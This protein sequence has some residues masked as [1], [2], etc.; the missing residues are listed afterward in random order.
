MHEPAARKVGISES[1]F[2]KRGTSAVL[3][4]PRNTEVERCRKSKAGKKKEIRGL[5]AA[6]AQATSQ[7]PGPNLATEAEKRHLTTCQKRLPTAAT[8]EEDTEF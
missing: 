3:A 6:R 4:K 7:S 8:E 1:A 2:I 5:G